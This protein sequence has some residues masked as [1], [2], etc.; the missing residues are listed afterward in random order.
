MATQANPFVSVDEYL[1][2]E[3]NSLERHEYLNGEIFMMAG[4]TLDHSAIAL[5][6]AAALIV[7]LADTDCIVRGSDARVRTSPTGLY[8][9]ADAVVSCG[10]EQSDKNTLLN[11]IVIVEILSEGTESYDR[12]KKFEFYRQIESFREYLVIAQDRVYVEHHR[13]DTS[14][15]TQWT[16]RVF[17]GRADVIALTAVP[18]NLRMEEIYRKLPVWNEIASR[19]LPA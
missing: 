19:E 9:Y 13:R 3:A 10:Q 5:N 4:G 11:P 1:E 12:G 14:I 18:A 17:A 8:S 6:V 15:P 7:Q 16:M 2:R